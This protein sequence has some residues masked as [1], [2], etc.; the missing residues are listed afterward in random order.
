MRTVWKVCTAFLVG[1]ALVMPMVS[2]A[3]DKAPMPQTRG[4]AGMDPALHDK[5]ASEK[6]QDP[7]KDCK[8]NA[9]A[10][11]RQ[12]RHPMPQTR[13]MAGMDPR[14]HEMDCPA[15]PV[16][17]DGKRPAHKGPRG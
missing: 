8:P 13:G 11:A 9:E 7:Y 3:E 15:A 14:L 6:G 16:T 17:A 5:W 1:L 4:M 12:A 2:A 10:A